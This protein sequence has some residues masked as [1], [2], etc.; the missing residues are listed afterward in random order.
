MSTHTYAVLEVPLHVYATVRMLLQQV[1]YEHA[2]HAGTR[3][4]EPVETIDMHGIGLQA[5]A[6]QTVVEPP[7][8]GERSN[9]GQAV[10]RLGPSLEEYL[11]RQHALGLVCQRFEVCHCTGDRVVVI[12]G[13]DRYNVEGNRLTRTLYGLPL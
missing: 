6:P 10:D 3:A 9:W 8:P 11:R 7:A 4:G 2:F 13:R 12:V 5:R 1:G